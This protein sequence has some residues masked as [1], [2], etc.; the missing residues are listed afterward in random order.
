[1]TQGVDQSHDAPDYWSVRVTV[2]GLRPT[3]VVADPRVQRAHDLIEWARHHWSLPDS[4][5]Y[6]LRGADG[7]Y[8]AGETQLDQ[9]PGLENDGEVTI[10]PLGTRAGPIPARSEARLLIQN[11]DGKSIVATVDLFLATPAAV[12]DFA[13]G[14]T[15][16]PPTVVYANGEALPNNVPLAFLGIAENDRLELHPQNDADLSVGTEAGETRVTKTA[17]PPLK[18]PLEP[19]AADV[20][21]TRSDGPSSRFA[22]DIWL[23]SLPFPLA[24]ILWQYHAAGEERTKLEYLTDFYEATAMF[25]GV[26]IVSAL[27]DV[28]AQPRARRAVD[29]SFSRAS[30]GGWVHL[31]RQTC[32]ALRDLSSTSEGAALLQ[33]LFGVSSTGTLAELISTEVLDALAGAKRYRN[34]WTAHGGVVGSEE[35]RRRLRILEDF[36]EPLRLPFERAFHDWRLV[37]PGRSLY[38]M[39]RHHHEVLLLAG[40]NARLRMVKVETGVP[41]D[42]DSLYMV[43]PAAPS[44]L[45]LVPLLA[46]EAAD[47]AVQGC[48]LYSRLEG[49]IAT[50]VSLSSDPTPMIERDGAVI[51]RWISRLDAL[52]A[53]PLTTQSLLPPEDSGTH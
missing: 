4:L 44:A 35:T 11:P 17:P 50:F 28:D 48:Y 6:R 43:D 29:P 32:P 37:I 14:G 39:G 19:L 34:E 5:E 47:E 42:A 45:Q 16:G 51:E 10:E 46:I 15:P 18:I 30:F 38:R 9:I 13:S 33:G 41:L 40:A 21:D 31:L 22:I 3:S 23:A 20:G 12:L 49:G 27:R 36:L 24:A 2:G 53:R 26:V 1:V 8:V 7:G 52:A 25:L